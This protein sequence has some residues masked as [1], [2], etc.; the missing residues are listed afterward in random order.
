MSKINHHKTVRLLRT[1][2]LISAITTFCAQQSTANGF[3]NP[4]GSASA[5]AVD[6]AK[7][8]MVDDVSSISINPANLTK[9]KDTTTLISLTFINAESTFKSPLGF[10]ADTRNSLKTLPDIYI[11]AP[12]KDDRFVAGLGITTPYGQSVE[13]AK[14]SG[15][16][17]FT[18]M[19]LVDIDPTLSIKLS[20]N[21]SVGAGLNCYY[22]QLQTKQVIPWS[23]VT[24]NP[25]AI[26]G[27]ANLK[28]DGMDVGA[29]IGVSWDIT[30]NQHVAAVY[31]SAFDIT[32]KGDTRVSG[33]PAPL[34]PLIS[35]KTDFESKIKFPAIATVGYALDITDTLTIGTEVEWV[36]FSRFKT[37][38][39]DLGANSSLGLFPTEIPQKWDDIWTF[40]LATAW[41]CS[42]AFVIR[43]S[44]KYLEGPIPDMTMAPTLPD[45]DKHT[46]GIGL[47]WK[48]KRQGVDVA[49]TYSFIADREIKTNQNPLYVGKYEMDSNIITI[50][51][52]R[53]L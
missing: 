25:R 48:G 19:I 2:A 46:L 18:K 3:R 8:V 10:S 39:I 12:F 33:I 38:P 30:E 27:T 31:H 11:A 32:Y 52:M 53:S 15:L 51:Y 4:P 17:Y 14:E 45:N 35:P 16:P 9:I 50:S 21:F 29:T 40:G 20:D 36:E 41:Q 6:G 5:L 44:Y 37:L 42:D 49:Y 47:G 43:G 26:S 28:G 13:W 23:M 24:G 34:S 22:S 7:S 1:F